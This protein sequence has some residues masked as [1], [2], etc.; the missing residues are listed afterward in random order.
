MALAL[1][2]PPDYMGLAICATIFFFPL[3]VF[4][5][6]LSQKVGLLLRLLISSIQLLHNGGLEV[7]F[8]YHMGNTPHGKYTTWEELFSVFSRFPLLL[9]CFGVTNIEII[10]NSTFSLLLETVTITFSPLKKVSKLRTSFQHVVSFPDWPG[11]ETVTPAI[12]G[13]RRWKGSHV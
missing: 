3:G 12:E 9:F 7:S 4:A 13:K 11:N 1:P 8:P 6:H 2:P 5:I 10:S